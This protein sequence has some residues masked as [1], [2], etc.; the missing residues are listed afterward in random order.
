MKKFDVVFST[1][2]GLA[3]AWIVNDFLYGYN[4]SVFYRLAFFVIL[5][6]LSI[7]GLWLADLIS[8]KL[9][10]VRQA[11]RFFLSGSFADVV[12]IKIF[13]LLFFIV[14]SYTL[15]LKAVSFLVAVLIKFWVNKY[16]TFEKNEKDGIRKEMVQFVGVTLVGLLLNVVSFYFFTK[17][18][19]SPETIPVFLWTELGVIFSALVTAVWNFLGYKLL[20]FK[21]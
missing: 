12:D 15:I 7:F 20:V 10:F 14:P 16:W 3:V 5:A 11:G 2:C 21:K 1:I 9:F 8:Q 19:S 4:V 18:L 6:L 13:Q 17:V